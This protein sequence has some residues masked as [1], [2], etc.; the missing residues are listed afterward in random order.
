MAAAASRGLSAAAGEAAQLR[1]VVAPKLSVATIKPRVVA[2]E[3]AVRGEIVRRAQLLE[4]ELQAGKRKFPFEK[5]VWCNIGNPQILGQKP[6]TYFRQVLC[7]CEYPQLLDHPQIGA[8]FPADVIERARVFLSDIPGGVGAYS[9]SAGALVLRKQ[10]AAAIERRDGYPASPDEIYL[11]DG[12]SPAVHYMM[13]MLMRSGQDAFLVPIPQYPLYSAT[14][15][16]YGGRLVP[17]ELDEAAGWG[18]NVDNLQA[19]LAAAQQQGLCVR[20][21]VVINPGNPT[22]QCLGADNQAEIVRFCEQ[23]GL[24]LI[25]DEVY[26]ANIYAADRTFTSFKQMVRQLE[27]SAMLVSLHSTSKG[28]VGECGRRGGY[29]EVVNFPPD[30]H[31][32]ILKLASINLCPNVSGQ[33][34]CTLMMTPPEEGE[35]SYDLYVQERDAVLGSLARRAATLVAGL[36]QLE[37]VSCNAAEGALYAFPRITLPAKAVAAAEALGKPGDWLYCSELLEATGIVVVPGSGFGQAAGSLHFRTTF[38]PP[39]EDIEGVV[40]K[41]GVFH[42]AFL[43]RYGGL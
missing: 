34:C 28:F 26:Q 40:R 38:L 43:E 31:E 22:G 4:D 32:Q 16:L 30:V 15:T 29:M 42:K 39:E 17:Y 19:Q 37:G 41:L 24:V 12:A 2:A 33:I 21:L 8:L 20:G 27:S 1:D 5:V 9:D 10:I 11:T 3:Y 7:L 13:E 23:H 25:A 14:L 36:N 18:L 35:P 6:I